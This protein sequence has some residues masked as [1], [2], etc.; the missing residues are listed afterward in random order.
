MEKINTAWQAASQE[1]Y[2][3]DQATDG[4][5]P[6]GGAPDAGSAPSEDEGVTDVNFEEVTD[7]EAK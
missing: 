6:M 3:A 4:A 2:A 5:D 7:S 1:I